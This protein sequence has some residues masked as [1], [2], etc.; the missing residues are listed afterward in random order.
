MPL[1]KID[2]K[3]VNDDA[4]YGCVFT[5]VDA[6]KMEVKWQARI[7]GN[8]DLVATSFDGKLAGTNQYNTENGVTYPDMMSAEVDACLIFNVARAIRQEFMS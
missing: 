8:C 2:A 6:E 3:T 1:E 4:N 7:D 5:C